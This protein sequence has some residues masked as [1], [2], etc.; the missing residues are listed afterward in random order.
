[1]EGTTFSI[2]ITSQVPANFPPGVVEFTNVASTT[3]DNAQPVSDDVTAT[4]TTP[5]ELAVEVSKEWSPETAT[6]GPG[7][8]STISLGVTNASNGAVSALVLQEP[9]TAVDGAAALDASNPFVLHDFAGFGDTSLPSGCDAVQVDVYVFDGVAWSWVEGSPAAAP[10]LPA[11][12]AEGDVGGLRFTCTGELILPDESVTIDL[13]LTQRVTDRNTDESFED[14]PRTTDNTASGQ[15]LVEGMDP[16]TDEASA[17]HTIQPVVLAAT[18]SKDIVPSRIPAGD[19]AEASISGSNASSDP[20]H[21]LRIS[22]LDY[23]TA[24]VTFGGFTS[25]PTWP[26]NA[27]SATFVYYP[28]EGGDPVSVPFEEGEI[29][30]VPA[31]VDIAGF[32]LVYTADGDDIVAGADVAAFFTIATDPNMTADPEVSTLNEVTA[33]VTTE[34]GRSESASDEDD[35]TIVEPAI[36]VTLEKS[37]LP[38]SPV[39]PGERVVTS[40]TS[41]TSA[42]SEYV[43]PSE[44]VVT[45]VWDGAADGF[46]NAFDLTGVAP[47]QVPPNTTL[48]VEVYVDGAWVR[49]ET[50][51]SQPDPRTVQLSAAQIEA[52]IAPAA[53]ED[54]TGIQFTFTADDAFPAGTTV[55][56]NLT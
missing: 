14:E 54:V 43:D 53:I 10:A 2:S 49:V 19:T 8:P 38:S 13:E 25:A 31:G 50:F 23:F 20:V 51:A 41:T 27:T 29:P 15:A 40:L 6:W 44:I 18:A 56:P 5:R 26:A 33:T 52:A 16:A 24:E 17:S 42:E 39:E 22:D 48:V 36:N 3:A 45:D 55:Q 21:E 35:L 12:V 32:E 37:V 4:I 11:G 47:T 28:L 7:T 34:S 30:T 46:W 9:Q 1:A